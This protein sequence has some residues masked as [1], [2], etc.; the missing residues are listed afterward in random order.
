MGRRRWGWV[1]ELPSG[2]WQASYTNNAIPGVA[3]GIRYYAP[4]TF[5][6]SDDAYAWLA[7]ER[8]MIETGQWVP[9]ADRIAAT[10][11]AAQAKRAAP[12]VAEFATR[13]LADADH[14][15]P[16]TRY[17]YERRIKYYICGETIPAATGK[18][19][20]QVTTE[21]LGSVK[22]ADV[23]RARVEAWWRSLPRDEYR[24]ACDQAYALLKELMAD[25]ADSGL[26]AETP[27]PRR[28]KRGV[29]KG[30]GRPSK[31]RTFKPLTPTQVVA[32]ADAMP[33]R[34][35]LGVLIGVWCALRSG[36][37]RELRRKDVDLANRT[38]HVRRAVTRSGTEFD[39]GETKTDAGKRDET[40][41]EHIVP[42]V[43]KHL[44]DHAQI[45]EE[46]LL[47]WGVR[48][49]NADDRTW[50]AVFIRACEAAG[51]PGYKFHDLRGTGLTYAHIAGYTTAELM[52]MAGHTSPAMVA[53]YQQIADEHK[54]EAD[55]SFNRLIAG[56]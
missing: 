46:G 47:F 49:G 14:L 41:P 37:V 42:D 27:M 39:I 33:P 26:I 19:A 8:R 16:T 5:D 28:A 56:A 36:E 40:I 7:G 21:G 45:G 51:V 20:R 4:G 53:R 48:G 2:R 18:P 54:A 38:I 32:V 13:W 12:T 10:R 1:R 22:V 52:A 29:L 11:A 6:G 15:R 9:P 25:A 24:R 31:R 43:E 35:R 3:Q 23:T 30:A 17:N 55:A 34:W 44:R 50:R